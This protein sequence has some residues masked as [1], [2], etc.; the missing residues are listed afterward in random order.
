MTTT[1]AHSRLHELGVKYGTDKATYH[2]YCDFY[3]EHLPD[4]ETFTGRLLEIGVWNG[5]S[6]AMWREYYPHAEEIVGI[7]IFD[8]HE[9]NGSIP[10]VPGCT[11]I[12]MD[13]T[14]MSVKTGL[15]SL[16][17]FDIIIDD[18]S[19][20]CSHQRIS[21]EYLFE[22]GLSHGGDY[23]V[24]DIH[25][26][27]PE[28]GYYHEEGGLT[29]LDYIESHPACGRAEHYRRDKN[30]ADSMTCIIRKPRPPRER[31]NKKGS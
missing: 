16:G 21:F 2:G 28:F 7:D 17:E 6:L 11:V 15:P 25:T 19:H 5:A 26:S 24:E 23:V 29:M 12:Q 22:W 20:L 8:L 9:A 27:L 14:D 18:G 10:S 3:A 1:P 30:V 4:P 13:Q 31:Q